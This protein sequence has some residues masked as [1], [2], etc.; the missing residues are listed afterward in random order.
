MVFMTLTSPSLQAKQIVQ[1]QALSV[2][3]D[4]SPLVPQWMGSTRDLEEAP[5]LDDY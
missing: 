5:P 1:K 2:C 4:C 3:H